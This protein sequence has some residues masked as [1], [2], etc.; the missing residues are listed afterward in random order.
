MS[1]KF[2]WE[3]IRA[4]TLR[5]I[6]QELG[7]K[8]LPTR[9]Q[10]ISFLETTANKEVFEIALATA[11]VRRSTASSPTKRKASPAAAN[12]EAHEYNTRAKKPRTSDPG[13]RRRKP[14]ERGT[15][16]TATLK[17]R[18]RGRPRK[19]VPTTRVDGEESDSASKSKTVFDGVI[20]PAKA[21]RQSSR[22]IQ[23]AEEAGDSASSQEG[24]D[25]NKENEPGLTEVETTVQ[26]ETEDNVQAT[27]AGDV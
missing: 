19:S 5:L 12:N 24:E 4:N 8:A 18:G 23:P 6:C 1:S 9:Q 25:S 10:M 14:T 27:N 7:Y 22:I 11:A 3:N 16:A 20:L 15:V 2:P 26:A 17:Q 13:P 21:R